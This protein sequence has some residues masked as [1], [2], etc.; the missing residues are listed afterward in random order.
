MFAGLPVLGPLWS[1]DGQGYVIPAVLEPKRGY[2][3]FLDSQQ[4]ELLLFGQ[5]AAHGIVLLDGGG[6]WNLVGPIATCPQPDQ[7]GVGKPVWDWNV[8]RG[9]YHSLGD[10]DELIPGRGYWMYA[11]GGD[12]S[13]D[14]RE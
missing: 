14:S 3:V 12:C 5:S 7:P 9:C 2:W 10:T 13:F 4:T 6:A 8:S 1:W 11:S